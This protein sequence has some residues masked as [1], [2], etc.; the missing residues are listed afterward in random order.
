MISKIVINICFSIWVWVSILIQQMYSFP[1]FVSNDCIGSFR[2]EGSIIWIRN[3]RNIIHSSKRVWDLYIQY[4][5]TC[6]N[7]QL[8]LQFEILPSLS[9][10][11]FFLFISLFRFYIIPCFL[12]RYSVS[13]YFKILMTSY[14][15]RMSLLMLINV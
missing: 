7:L 11:S 3:F 15:F 2:N 6:W 14:Q 4:L 1:A 8:F 9:Y 12:L 13:V 5:Y 10:S